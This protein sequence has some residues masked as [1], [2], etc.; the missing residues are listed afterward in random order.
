MSTTE[1]FVVVLILGLAVLAF[2]FKFGAIGGGGV[3]ARRDENPILYWMG[4]VITG[5]I[6]LT[7]LVILVFVRPK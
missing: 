6:V 5:L 4:V 2:A 3:G 1:I 7:A